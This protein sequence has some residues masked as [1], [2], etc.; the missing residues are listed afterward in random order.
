MM[1]LTLGIAIRRLR[2]SSTPI[3]KIAYLTDTPRIGGAERFLVD[4]AE[5]AVRAGHEVTVLAPQA[6]LLRL[7][8]EAIPRARL[9]E[10]RRPEYE[11]A[12]FPIASL[13]WSLPDLRST[14]SCV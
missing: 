12:R 2:E 9:I 13:A 3:M 8:E 6:F 7:F 4:I 1:T 14:M 5:G 10:I 11:A